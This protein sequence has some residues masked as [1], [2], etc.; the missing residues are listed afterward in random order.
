MGISFG[1][2]IGLLGLAGLITGSGA[3]FRP[4]APLAA[5]LAGRPLFFWDPFIYKEGAL[6]HVFFG[7]LFCR[8]GQTYD[9]T[10]NPANPQACRLDDAIFAIGYALDDGSG[11]WRFRHT[12]V[13]FPAAAG[14]WDDHYIETPSLVRAG[15]RYLLFYSAWP[16]ARFKRYQIGVAALAGGSGLG[17]RLLDDE[18]G[19]QRVGSAPLIPSGDG[20]GR[21]NTQ[22]P[23]VVLNGRR[24]EIFYLGLVADRK[25][26]SQPLG[27]AGLSEQTADLRA[28]S[29]G[30]RCFDF[31]LR[32]LNCGPQPAALLQTRFEPTGPS[33][34]MV[35][36]PEVLL[37]R[38]RYL[39]FYTDL[40]SG[41]GP[42]FQGNHLSYRFAPDAIHWSDAIP[43]VGPS[44][45]ESAWGTASP[46]AAVMAVSARALTL[47]FAFTGWGSFKPASASGTCFEGR[48]RTP[49]DLAHRRCVTSSLMRGR[50]RVTA[51]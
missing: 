21:E 7:S 42:Y 13:L 4:E 31:G 35:N 16:K 18:S 49:L 27:A 44:A 38:G 6:T 29:L 34:A 10:W 17:K 48:F 3:D 37:V 11:R 24:L 22:E 47:D 25:G 2:L 9:Y 26:S 20:I 23:S 32:A 12:P 41:R 45:G 43:L 39:L 36:T 46:T 1:R 14:A 33:G 8:R 19:F 15:G 5:G 28:I 51:F 30:R 40:G 50:L